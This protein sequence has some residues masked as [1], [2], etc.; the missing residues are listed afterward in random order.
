M[1]YN[2]L[3]FPE[4]KDEMNCWTIHSY[5]KVFPGKHY[6]KQSD[7][8]QLRTAPKLTDSNLKPIY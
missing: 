2:I 4:T 7:T 1:F 3:T 5:Q 8:G 6:S